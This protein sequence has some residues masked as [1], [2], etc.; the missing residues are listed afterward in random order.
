VD[1]ARVLGNLLRIAFL[2]T[3]VESELLSGSER[4]G[5][6]W[7]RWCCPGRI[8]GPRKSGGWPV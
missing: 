2:V 5:A 8:F 7:T 6:T 1:I 4:T 3:L